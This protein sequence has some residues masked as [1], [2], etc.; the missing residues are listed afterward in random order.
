MQVS[1]FKDK[2]K[3]EIAFLLG[4]GPSLHYVDIDLIKDYV[5]MA[6]NSALTSVSCVCGGKA[7]AVCV[8][9]IGISPGKRLVNPMIPDV[10]AITIAN[11]IAMMYFILG[12]PSAL[13]ISVS[14]CNTPYAELNGHSGRSRKIFLYQG[15]RR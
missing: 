12:S 3:G 9:L 4:A 1:D 2:H 11:I 15:C 8:D 7:A 13:L 6:V 14:I 5:C 10:R